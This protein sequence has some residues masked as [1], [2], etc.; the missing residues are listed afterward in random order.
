MDSSTSQPARSA[1]VILLAVLAND[2]RQ[3]D[4]ADAHSTGYDVILLE[5]VLRSVRPRLDL[6]AGTN[7]SRDHVDPVT[8]RD[9]RLEYKARTWKEVIEQS[10]L[11]D[12]RYN[13]LFLFSAS[14]AHSLDKTSYTEFKV[15]LTRQGTWLL[16]SA[17]RFQDDEAGVMV[18][19]LHEYTT[20]EEFCE[21]AE[22]LRANGYLVGRHWGG[23]YLP[24][25]LAAKLQEALGEMVKNRKS[26][27]DS[28][29]RAASHVDQVM[30]AVRF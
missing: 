13:V 7:L 26:H 23:P 9:S 4:R 1:L 17:I 11:L 19:H 8:N 24:I 5:K 30:A 29:E 14:F 3:I 27:L 10:D 12:K 15:Y 2:N 28:L 16:W 18:E 6:L 22:E 25:I 21:A 20:T